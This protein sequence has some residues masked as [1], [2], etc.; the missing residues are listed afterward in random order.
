V[1]RNA[2]FSVFHGSTSLAKHTD[3]VILDSRDA[4][5]TWVPEFDCASFDMT[6]FPLVVHFRAMLQILCGL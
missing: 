3:S 4:S 5:G 2:S 6:T 1:K